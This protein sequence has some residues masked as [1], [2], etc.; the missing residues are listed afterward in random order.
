MQSTIDFHRR[1]SGNI[2]T[3]I[4]LARNPMDP[5]SWSPPAAV[6]LRSIGAGLMAGA[7]M[8]HL[9]YLIY[10]YYTLECM[11]GENGVVV[12]SQV[13]ATLF[14]FG[15]Q[16][17][18]SAIM[19]AKG[20]GSNIALSCDNRGFF[21][22]I[23]IEGGIMKGRKHVNENFYAKKGIKTADILFSGDT[24]DV[25]SG[26]ML[27]ELYVK[28][29]KLCGGDSVYEPTP[30][31]LQKIESTRE[32]VEREEAKAAQQLPF[33]MVVEG[34]ESMESPGAA[35]EALGDCGEEEATIVPSII[36]DDH[37]IAPKMSDA[38]IGFNSVSVLSDSDLP[39]LAEGNDE[40]KHKTTDCA[41][42]EKRF[43]AQAEPYIESGR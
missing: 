11:S 18:M 33:M 2:G 31:E 35:L 24:Y 16:A 5:E 29:K 39:T 8:K 13:E 4:V 17:E 37:D 42:M 28:L 41:E 36:H 22:G 14:K 20:V 9:V 1:D 30:E 26:T 43:E 10:D 6:G 21:G 12:S 32:R 27:P 3:G 7:S 23:S 40:N 15:R 34:E 25:P 19:S 38:S